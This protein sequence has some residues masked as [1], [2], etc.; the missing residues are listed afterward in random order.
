VVA[1]VEQLVTD[2]GESLFFYYRPGS[3]APP[4]PPQKKRHGPGPRGLRAHAASTHSQ[5]VRS[6]HPS[7]LVAGVPVGATHV[8]A[9]R[10]EAS[11][12]RPTSVRPAAGLRRCVRRTPR[13]GLFPPGPGQSALQPTK[14][15]LCLRPPDCGSPALPQ[16]EHL[17][18]DCRLAVFDQMHIDHFCEP[19]RLSPGTQAPRATTGHF[20]GRALQPPPGCRLPFST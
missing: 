4:P 9:V 14:E 3:E 13:L 12:I 5:L 10:V 1:V 19:A 18:S 17:Y 8:A 11:S 20:E 15:D 7:A 2:E 16:V 6:P